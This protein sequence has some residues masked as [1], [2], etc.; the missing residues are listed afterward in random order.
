M[1]ATQQALPMAGAATTRAAEGSVLRV[2][3][4]A[5]D[6]GRSIVKVLV[7]GTQET[8]LGIAP[9][10]GAGAVV[11]G[12]GRVEVDPK[13]GVQMH[14]ESIVPTLPTTTAGIEIY[15]A[16]AGLPGVGP[17]LA[18]AIVAK[19]GAKTF[20]VMSERP[21]DLLKVTGIGPTK[22]DGIV[23]AWADERVTAELMA[24]LE[25][26]GATPSVAGRIVRRYGA[27]A[28]HV[29][30][31][32]PYRLAIEVERVGFKTAD[33]IA[34]SIGIGAD[35]PERAQAATLHTLQEATTR[36]DCYLPI[37]VL[38][39]KTAELISRPAPE[40]YDAIRW[41]AAAPVPPG[42]KAPPGAPNGPPRIVI[43]MDAEG[44]EIV[45]PRIL[46][47]AEV[48]LTERLHAMLATEARPLPGAEEAIADFELEAGMTLAA[49][50]REA[51]EAAAR[52]PI[53]VVTG[54]PGT[55]KSTVA[56]ALLMVLDRARITTR[57]ASPTGRAAK[58][59]SETTG[60]EASTIH[61][62]LGMRD[63]GRGFMHDREHPLPCGAL[64]GD[65][66]SMMDV[67]LANALVQALP[68]K[69]RLLIIGDVDQLP[70]VGPGAVLR[71]II[72]SGA[73]PTVRLSQVFRQAEG[74][75]ILDAAMRVNS[76]RMPEG[77]SLDDGVDG[78]FFLETD[79]GEDPDQVSARGAA[80]IVDIATNI[81]PARFGFH[82][83]DE[84]QV[85]VPMIK[86]GCGTIALNQALQAT[87]NPHG[88]ALAS[89]PFKFRGGDKVI[90]TKNDYDKGCFNGDIGYVERVDLD[91]ARLIVSIDGREVL[92]EK[93]ELGDLMLA[94]AISCHRFQGSE[95]PAVVVGLLPEH[96]PVASR[97]W[98]YTALT[99]GKKLVV[100]VTLPRVLGRAVRETRREV[101]RTGLAARLR[102]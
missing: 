39:S 93:K 30:S 71:D 7:N 17:A 60:R 31:T 49:A 83:R 23:R 42:P 19:F 65:E 96:Y 62:L 84:V 63:G 9:P 57:L 27:Q 51:V 1:M 15:L 72:S 99:R 24:F 101:R 35:S 59:L 48:A 13:W 2:V 18:K 68:T 77:P 40:C 43:E 5:E 25:E 50:Q 29:V 6:T 78:E 86:G 28:M 47:D 85:I 37:A 22:L 98:T 11:R 55:G 61:R 80:R 36:G 8:W 32:Q 20:E 89:G 14:C 100:L 74:S 34:Q 44:G 90:V 76:G 81:I 4:Y 95:A 58:R 97:P 41:L 92:F 73:V 70:S 53:V 67:Q 38:A 75:S 16:N 54:G 69:A 88:H 91:D 64:M 26:H 87:L 56:K 12:R 45:Y 79:L 94:Y 3:F 52:Y 82:P 102:G 33:I 66:A 10:L 21:K 46:H